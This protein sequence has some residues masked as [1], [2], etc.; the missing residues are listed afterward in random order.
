L[1]QRPAQDLPQPVSGDAP[2]APRPTRAGDIAVTS[3]R[4]PS[5]LCSCWATTGTTSAGRPREIVRAT[6]TRD[7]QR[8]LPRR[9]ASMTVATPSSSTG[10]A[11]RPPAGARTSSAACGRRSCCRPRRVSKDAEGSVRRGGR[12]VWANRTVVG[13]SCDPGSFASPFPGT[14]VEG[15]DWPSRNGSDIRAIQ[16]GLPDP[17]GRTAPVQNRNSTNRRRWPRT[18]RLSRRPYASRSD[19]LMA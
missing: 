4:R 13:D 7:F 18:R 5:S 16:H 17:T 2:V 8:A 19:N 3:D 6:R 1:E 10:R 11:K 14:N 9:C 12:L 15:G